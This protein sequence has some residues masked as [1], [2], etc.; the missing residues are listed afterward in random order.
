[1][2]GVTH[3]ARSSHVAELVCRCSTC[4]AKQSHAALQRRVHTVNANFCIPSAKKLDLCSRFTSSFCSHSNTLKAATTE[5]LEEE[6]H[7]SLLLLLHYMPCGLST[8][9]SSFP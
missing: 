2:D 4:A 1:M 7:S 3:S 8:S 6:R 5:I 9:K